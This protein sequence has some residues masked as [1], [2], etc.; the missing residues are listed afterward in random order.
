MRSDQGGNTARYLPLLQLRPPT[1]TQ[2]FKVT[3][4]PKEQ[5]QNKN[6]ENAFLKDS[7]ADEM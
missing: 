7:A 2:A 6:Q 5:K 4:G 3:P 1:P